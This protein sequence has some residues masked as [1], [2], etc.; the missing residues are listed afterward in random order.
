MHLY[1]LTYYSR[2]A[3]DLSAS[4][5]RHEIGG[6]MKA[7]LENNAACGITGALMF[8]RSWFLQALEGDRAAVTEAFIRI[9]RDPRHADIVILDCTSTDERRFAD[10]S[11]AFVDAS[12]MTEAL[13]KYGPSDA[14]EPDRLSVGAAVDLLEIAARTGLRRKDAA[15]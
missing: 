15:A 3:L 1:R 14:F 5:L 2:V 6:I 12:D 8:D 13:T 4:T 10:W 7:S 11:M 9:A